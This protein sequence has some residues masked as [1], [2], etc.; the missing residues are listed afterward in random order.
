M[1]KLVNVA[2]S[3]AVGVQSLKV[4]DSLRARLNWKY[5]ASYRR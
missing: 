3:E 4:R 2:V 1:V 5:I